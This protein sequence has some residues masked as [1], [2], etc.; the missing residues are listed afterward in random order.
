M[1]VIF[2]LHTGQLFFV[3]SSLDGADF[4]C[5]LKPCAQWLQG[6]P[7]SAGGRLIGSVRV[8]LGDEPGMLLLSF[9]RVGATEWGPVTVAVRHRPSATQQHSWPADAAYP[10]PRYVESSPGPPPPVPQPSHPGGWTSFASALSDISAAQAPQGGREVAQLQLLQAQALLQLARDA[11]ALHATQEQPK[12][13]AARVPPGLPPGDPEEPGQG[14]RGPRFPQAAG[15]GPLP[16]RVSPGGAAWPQSQDR[17]LSPSPQRRDLGSSP[18]QIRPNWRTS[19]PSVGGGVSSAMSLLSQPTDLPPPSRLNPHRDAPPRSGAPS[20]E[21]GDES[22]SPVG[23][24]AATVLPDGVPTI[25][26]L[27]HATGNCKPCFFMHTRIGCQYG[28]SCLFCHGGHPKRKQERPQKFQRAEYR[29]LVEEMFRMHM[30]RGLSF[31]EADAELQRSEQFQNADHVAIRHVRK[32]LRS[33][34]RD[35]GY[36]VA[37]ASGSVADRGS[38]AASVTHLSV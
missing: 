23:Q 1:F 10:R 18:S 12:S 3:S 6:D 25:G 30:A 22:Q 4:G 29:R 27:G 37:E 17:P 38:D 32:L 11:E 15:Q 5:I 16:P 2:A 19:P 8:R 31:P 24:L 13:L 21:E 26:T 33:L 35:A 7:S 28:A 34:Y 9:K 20:T 14:S 36:D